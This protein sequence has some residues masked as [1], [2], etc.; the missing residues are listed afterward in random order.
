MQQHQGSGQSISLNCESLLPDLLLIKRAYWVNGLERAKEWLESP[1]WFFLEQA[2]RLK[3]CWTRLWLRKECVGI[4]YK[5]I[6]KTPNICREWYYCRR[7]KKSI[8]PQKPKGTPDNFLLYLPQNNELTPY[9]QKRI[10][11]IILV[12][13]YLII[14]LY[15]FGLFLVSAPCKFSVPF[16]QGIDFALGFF[17]LFPFGS[18]AGF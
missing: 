8:S 9:T 6:K 2:G 14:S 5:F 3:Y 16:H 11:P 12:K 13:W 1:F 7:K 17:A 15:V 4:L 10:T 18:F